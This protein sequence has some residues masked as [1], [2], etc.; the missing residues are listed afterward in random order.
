MKNLKLL[1]FNK[2]AQKG[3]GFNR[4]VMN[5]RNRILQL[6]FVLVFMMGIESAYA[7]SI[8]GCAGGFAS[9]GYVP[10][11]R[12]HF[13]GAR[14]MGNYSSTVH[15]LLFENDEATVSSD[16]FHRVELWGRYAINSRL[17]ANVTLPYHYNIMKEGN[18]VHRINGIGDPMLSLQYALY[19]TEDYSIAYV[20]H[21]IMAGAGIQVPLGANHYTVDDDIWVPAFQPGKGSVGLWLDANYS[22]LIANAG[23]YVD[24][25]ALMY[26]RNKRNYQYGNQYNVGISG[27]YN[28]FNGN[29][30]LVPEIGVQA[31]V[32]DKDLL[33]VKD[34]I[35]NVLSG[36][37]QVDGSAGVSLYTESAIWR[38]KIQQALVYN[39]ADGYVTPGSS[40]NLQFLYMINPIQKNNKYEIL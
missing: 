3:A 22:M 26:S 6:F 32:K 8:C 1:R 24:V 19:K 28:F 31:S 23:L 40:V 4:K 25:S 35:A 37:W 21:M 5:I 15:P 11:G 14:Y 10:E 33:S 18:K 27:F 36:G 12:M 39:L 20:R 30:R 29:N 16:Y 38:L 7:C 34:N 17:Y 9:L 13:A 2:P